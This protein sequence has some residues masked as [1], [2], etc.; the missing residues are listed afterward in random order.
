MKSFEKCVDACR[1][2]PDESSPRVKIA[3]L[4]T[5]LDLSHPDM[6]MEYKDGRIKCHDFIDES[7]AIEDLDGHGTH[8]TSTLAKIAPN[9]EIYIGRVFRRCRAENSS[10]ATV[11]KVSRAWCIIAIF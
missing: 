10:L 8:C 1:K 6:L 11:V 2:E 9:A 5:G 4:D 3:I 7:T